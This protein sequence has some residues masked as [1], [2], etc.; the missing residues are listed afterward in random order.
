MRICPSLDPF[1]IWLGEIANVGCTYIQ[2][3]TQRS[4]IVVGASL[5]EKIDQDNARKLKKRKFQARKGETALLFPQ[6][7]PHQR[8]DPFAR[9]L[10]P[11]LGRDYDA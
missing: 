8:S 7:Q 4:E 10:R 1:E 6:R 5:L 3:H 11:L 9:D 2:P